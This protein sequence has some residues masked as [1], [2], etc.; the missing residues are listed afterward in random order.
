MVSRTLNKTLFSE[1]FSRPLKAG[2][3]CLRRIFVYRKL[4]RDSGRA[5]RP[6][7]RIRINVGF[8]MGGYGIR[9]YGICDKYAELK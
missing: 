5:T 1:D 7:R 2:F 4:L 6:L 9:P 3:C 8:A